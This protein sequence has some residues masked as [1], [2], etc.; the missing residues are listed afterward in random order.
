MKIAILNDTH[1]GVRNS[2]EI[3]IEY[4]RKFYEDVFFPYCDD[5]NITQVIHL[6]D[7]YD[8]R[9]NVN[10]KALNSNRRMFLEPLRD[11]GMTMDIIPGNHD[12]YHKNTND[13][14]SLKELLGYYTSNVNIIMNPTSVEY[15]GCSINLLPWISANNYTQSMDF[16][17][18]NDGIIM[19]HL[20]L[21][22]FELMRGVVQ[23][24]GMSADIFSHYDQVLSGHYHVAS[25]VGNVRY[26]GSQMEFTWADSADDKFFHVFDTDTKE[27]TKVRNPYTLFEKIYYDDT[28]VDYHKADVSGYVNKFV[29]VVVET[30]NDPFMFDKF[31]DKLSDIETYE[32]KVVENFQEF[33]GENVTTSI[34]D[35]DNTT[36]L[37]YNYI[38]GVNTDLDKDKLKTLM[39]TLYNEALDMEIT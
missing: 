37:M 15:D 17:K 20:E 33:L 38:D 6:G 2:S 18:K 19:A 35:V 22:G 8:H 11:K 1:S 12:V 23:T 30:K 28:N 7:Y 10:F 26:L 9:K 21:S 36:D 32:L 24:H 25:Q 13:L 16:I 34:E 29:K 3:F 5:N 4:Q 27:I 39:N 14:C 31:I